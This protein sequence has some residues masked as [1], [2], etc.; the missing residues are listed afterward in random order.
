MK[1]MFVFS[2]CN[3]AAKIQ[4]ASMLLVTVLSASPRANAVDVLTGMN[5]NNR[6]GA[7]IGETTLNTTNVNVGQFGK[8]WS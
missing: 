6:T 2:Y 4:A 8:L 7:N 3:R 5:D 1:N